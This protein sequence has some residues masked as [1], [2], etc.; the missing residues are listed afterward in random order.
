MVL[1]PFVLPGAEAAAGGGSA[2]TPLAALGPT[3]GIKR[4]VKSCG[5]SARRQLWEITQWWSAPP[6]IGLCRPFFSH[7][8]MILLLTGSSN[9]EKLQGLFSISVLPAAPFLPGLFLP[10]F[11]F[12]LLN[13]L[14][15]SPVFEWF[16][17]PCRSACQHRYISFRFTFIYANFTSPS[18]FGSREQLQGFLCIPGYDLRSLR[19]IKLDAARALMYIQAQLL[20][21]SPHMCSSLFST[22]T[23]ITFLYKLIH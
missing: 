11:Q 5:S 21:S 18:R 7:A 15:P 14:N 1:Q 2:P 9:S 20:V 12:Y 10:S 8:L 6:K 16:H 17:W 4:W 23:V 13:M 3:C 22:V 19:R